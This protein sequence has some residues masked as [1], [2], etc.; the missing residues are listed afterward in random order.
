MLEPGGLKLC[1][2]ALCA[3][4]HCRVMAGSLHGLGASLLRAV[5]CLQVVLVSRYWTWPFVIF[6]LL[7]YWLVFPFEV[8]PRSILKSPFVSVMHSVSGSLLEPL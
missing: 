5:A 7:S 2:G 1:W 6:V 4:L 8:R 3:G